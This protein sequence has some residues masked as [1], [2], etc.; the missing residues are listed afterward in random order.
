[1]ANA[2]P[3]RLGQI[4]EAGDAKALFLKVFSGEVL[5]AFHRN[6]VFLEKTMVRTISS[7]K[8]AQFPATGV[9]TASYHTVGTEINGTSVKHAER[10]ISIDDL[11]IASTFIS[12]IDEAM[13]H[14]DV[15]SVYS[16]EMGK[17]LAETMDS[18]IAQVGVLAARATATIT[19]QSGGSAL[20]NATYGSDSAVLASGLFSAQ[21]ILDEKNIGSDDRNAFLRPAQ[22]YL[23]AQ[24]T[25]VIN[26]WYGGQ[27]A[28]AEG[29]ILKVGGINIVKTNALPN[30]NITTGVTTYQGNFSTTVG[31]VMNKSAVGTVKLMDLATESEY[32]IR[33]QGTLMVGKYAVGH[34]IL[35]PECAVELKSA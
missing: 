29:T 14:Y 6:N 17:V 24:N 34:G 8:T 3:S 12:N 30:T 20:T 26:Q 7:G 15:R 25:T 21:Q 4:N 28:I 13:N 27:G 9:V 18:N 11:L 31:L 35:R 5:T 33:R 19:G 22:Y 32:D 1:M 2:V 10:N 16:D 23:L